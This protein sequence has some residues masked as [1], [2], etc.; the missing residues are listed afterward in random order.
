MDPCSC[1]S[2]HLGPSRR[3]TEESRD[4]H[5][6]Q[7]REQITGSQP[8]LTSYGP[9]RV[10]I[11]KGSGLAQCAWAADDA[12]FEALIDRA[13]ADDGPQFIVARTDASPPARVTARDA[14]KIRSR[15]M[16]GLGICA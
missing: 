15:F 3:P 13:L 12:H 9:D 1:S 8:T 14:A 2:G 4:R 5:L 16:A 7:R 11:A 6:R 10:A